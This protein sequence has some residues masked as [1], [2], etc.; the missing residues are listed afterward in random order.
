MNVILQ[1]RSRMMALQVYGAGRHEKMLVNEM[2]NPVR[3]TVRD[4]R[5]EIHGSVFAQ[6]SGHVHAR[7]LLE[8]GKTDVRIRFVVAQKYVE[9]WLVALDQLMLKGQRLA[10]VVHNDGFQISN[11][12]HQRSGFRINRARFKK[13]GFHAAAQRSGLAHIQNLP[14]GTLEQIHPGPY[15]KTS[16]FLI[17]IHGRSTIAIQ[18]LL[19]G[20]VYAGFGLG[21]GWG[22]SQ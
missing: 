8:R 15:G 6:A 2:H 10:R 14:A 12:A 13:I 1:T 16:G 18:I 17:E 9:F 7:I 5:P 20:W 3:E 19:Y 21:W 22:L 11:F 4:I